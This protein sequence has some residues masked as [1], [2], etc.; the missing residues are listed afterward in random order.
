MV[1]AV[2]DLKL[3]TLY[4][5]NRRRPEAP[6]QHF[7]ARVSRRH[8]EGPELFFFRRQAFMQTASGMQIKII[9]SISLVHI[10]KTGEA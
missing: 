9:G 2:K 3:E 8:E 10:H 7:F 5:E 1:Q 4:Q 6:V